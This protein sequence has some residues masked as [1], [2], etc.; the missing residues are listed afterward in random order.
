MHL[1]S[2]TVF[3]SSFTSPY[4]VFSKWFYMSEGVLSY[5]AN[6]LGEQIPCLEREK[7]D[8]RINGRPMLRQHVSIFELVCLCVFETYVGTSWILAILAS[9]SIGPVGP[10][11]LRCSAVDF[12]AA[13]IHPTGCPFLAIREQVSLALPLG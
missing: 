7:K 11:K 10:A 4:P 2:I 5:V 6:L 8:V 9:Q 1:H 12:G 3:T 13:S